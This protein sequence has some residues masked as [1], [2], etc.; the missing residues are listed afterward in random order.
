MDPSI[1]ALMGGP[2]RRSFG[3]VFAHFQQLVDRRNAQPAPTCSVQN[4]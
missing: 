2:A 1:I 3:S 4:R